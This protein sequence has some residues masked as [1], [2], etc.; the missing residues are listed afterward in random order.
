MSELRHPFQPAL[1][2][3]PI[4]LAA[5]PPISEDPWPP[6]GREDGDGEIIRVPR[7]PV[8]VDDPGPPNDAIRRDEVGVPIAPPYPQYNDDAALFTDPAGGRPHA[9]PRYALAY[10][11]V[12]SVDEPRITI[13]DRAG[14]ATLLLTLAETPGPA[15]GPNT[16]RL[17][18]NVLVRLMLRMPV[19]GGAPI[20]QTHAF[21]T[22]RVNAT[23]GTVTAELPL[24][25]PGL[26]QQLL[27][28]FGSL[29]ASV[30]IDV[31]R[32]VTLAHETD[33]RFESGEVMWV[34]H[35][36]SLHMRVPPT[37]LVLPEQQRVRLGGGGGGVEPA[38]RIRITYEG[39][40]HA[41]W[42]DPAQPDRFL[43]LPDRFLLARSAEPT[44][45]PLMR[46]SAANA[47]SEADLAAVLE[48]SAK[49]VVDSQRLTA[50]LATLTEEAKARG[51][52]GAVRLERL[53]EAQSLL[54]LAL[55]VN[56]A[57][58][59][60]LT[61]RPDTDIDLERGVVHAERFLLED[62]R[63]VYDALFGVSLSLLRGEIRVG[64]GGSAP[65]DVPLELRLDR[66]TGDMLVLQPQPVSQ[67][68]IPARLSNPTESAVTSLGTLRAVAVT[69]PQPT[70][71]TVVRPVDPTVPLTI[72]GLPASG[73]LGPGE[74]CDVTLSGFSAQ[75]QVE[76][77]ALD[78]SRLTVDPDRAAIWALVFDRR[79]EGRLTRQVRA[80]AVAEMFGSADR[81]TDRV[82]TFVL[83]VENGG[84]ASL[85]EAQPS[86]ETT[87][88]VPVQPLLT[89][90]PLPPVRYRTETHWRSGG[91]G[92]SPWRETDATILVPV[93]TNPA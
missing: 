64:A 86:A 34:V 17:A 18:H 71:R 45:P 84:S 53:Q 22:S 5:R 32:E 11:R 80:Q 9:L 30:T 81:P 74:S 39:R 23:A 27:A 75:Q 93:R 79:T 87:V 8:P 1:V 35:T 28:A 76:S 31:Y 65:E 88:R 52:T 61:D 7:R 48:F 14:V 69:T 25:T 54:R 26:R 13:V 6:P 66:T 37:P 42:Q 91:I 38:R 33:W 49:P 57:P 82:L 21:P 56:G 41:Y 19:L 44:R 55:P 20:T 60:T 47:S 58:P 85:T 50:A 92:V 73:R 4:E 46:I 40:S 3:R 70:M 67:G 16:Q 72:S 10:D 51:G 43:F 77:V 68:V 36:S 89:G 78:Q 63:L 29:E 90:A 2:L 15:T 59:S 24:T 83:T 12:G 62:F